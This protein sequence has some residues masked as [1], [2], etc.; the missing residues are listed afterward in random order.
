[1]QNK[2]QS[3]DEAVAALLCDGS[4]VTSGK[5]DLTAGCARLMEDG[6]V[7]SILSSRL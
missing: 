6:A 4:W 2:I 7:D 5:A 3:C 1:M